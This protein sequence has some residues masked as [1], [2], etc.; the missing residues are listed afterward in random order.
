MAKKITALDETTTISDEDLVPIVQGNDTKYTEVG[1][2][3][4]TPKYCKATTTTD[5]TADTNY[6]VVLNDFR[7]NT[8]NFTFQDGGIRIPA[9]INHIRLSGSVFLNN[10][11]G[12]TNYLWT[13]I[14]R[15]RGQTSDH[16]SGALNNSTATF[17]SSSVPEVITNVQE[18]DIIKIMADSPRG[19][20]IRV[21]GPNTWLMVEKID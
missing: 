8:G 10:F 17:I 4:P 15:V 13:K 21:Y 9:G 2:L 1:N 5:Q 7:I 18:G 14:Y 16:I 20:T 12:G 6:F 11:P 3:S 19:G